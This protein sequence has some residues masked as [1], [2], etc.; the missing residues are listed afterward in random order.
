MRPFVDVLAGVFPVVGSREI[1]AKEQGASRPKSNFGGPVLRAFR[2][3][4]R[5]G[6][7]PTNWGQR[8]Q[9][10]GWKRIRTVNSSSR[11]AIIAPQSVSFTIA[12]K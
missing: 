10:S 2:G 11:P 4:D 8:L 3:S 6:N 1:D 5:A 9:N 7:Q 12:E